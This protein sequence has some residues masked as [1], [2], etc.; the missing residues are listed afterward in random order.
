MELFYLGLGTGLVLLLFYLY[1]RSSILVCA[2]N[3]VIVLSGMARREGDTVA[4][5]RVITEGRGHMMPIVEKASR[6]DLSPMSV[7]FHATGQE[8]GHEIQGSAIVK[9]SKTEPLLHSAITHFLGLRSDE[10]KQHI[11]TTVAS[12]FSARL[13]EMP[14]EKVTKENLRSK[15][16][17]VLSSL[18]LIAERID[19]DTV[20]VGKLEEVK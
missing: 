9:V 13:D 20:K 3:E 14:Q 10:V 11:A 4:G 15:L 8:S 5:Y 12:T 1:W 2:P 16:E 18:G 19:F 17:Q 7:D 6:L